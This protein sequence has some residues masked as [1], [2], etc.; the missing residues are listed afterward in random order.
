MNTD[1]ARRE[2]RPV[3]LERL[4]EVVRPEFRGDVFHPPAD[5]P[6][7]FYGICRVPACPIA[8]SAGA[9]MLCSSHYQA[10]G[11]SPD[12]EGGIDGWIASV[13]VKERTGLTACAVEGCNRSRK[14]PA[15]CSR[16]H[17]AWDAAGRPDIDGWLEGHSY[18]PP[19]GNDRPETTCEGP[20]CDRWTEGPSRRLC[21]GHD[22]KWRRAGRGD[23][24]TWLAELVHGENPRLRLD[25]LPRQLRLELQFGLQCRHDEAVKLAPIRALT[26]AVRLAAESG[27]ESLLDL[28]TAEWNIRL[29]GDRLRSFN[30][31]ARCF[32]I[33]TR[34]RL[35]ALLIE[36]DPWADQYP[37]DRWDLRL[38]GLR[39][40]Q[41][42]HL[43]FGPIPQLWLRD[44]AR[45]WCRWQLSRGL[46]PST[47]TGQLAACRKLAGYLESACPDAAPEDLTRMRVEAWL[48]VVSAALPAPTR[49]A[50][51]C[52]V[53]CFLNDV[54]RHGWEP[55]LPAG[56]LVFG[57]DLPTV[58]HGK[59][60]WIEEQ[61]MRQLEAPVALARFPTV[62][63]GVLVRILIECGL[64]LKDARTLPFDCVTRDDADAPYLAWLN[65]K[66]ADRPAF[67]PISEDLA[68]TITGQQTRVSERFPAGCRWL[69]PARSANLDGSKHLGDAGFRGQ[70]DVW[71]ERIELR[72]ARG[73]PV[74]VTAHQ[75]RHTLG[76]RL[77]NRDVPQHVVQ[78]LLDHMSPEM[79]AVYARLHDKTVRRHWE[80]ATRLNADGEAVAVDRDHPLAD[81]QWTKTRLGRA[82]VTLPNGYCGAPV[83][84]DCEYA[85]PCLDCGFFLTTVE[86]LPLHRRQRD[87]TEMMV[88]EAREQ[89]LV[90][91]VERNTRTLARLDHLIGRLEQ[92]DTDQIDSD[93][94][95][96]QADAA[97]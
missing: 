26:A 20:G 54:H 13:D 53:R 1:H 3:L 79:T 87:D 32:L 71:F 30:S 73:D 55:R 86:F 76:T 46:S 33:D 8:V 85:N 48:A 22:E 23:L 58:K 60:R 44:L 17:K 59:P 45:R 68:V 16:H 51:V 14:T 38:L 31:M 95:C 10:W 67:F 96:G 2:G 5:S 39:N 66:M 64:R 89:G 7:F 83:Q 43:D 18:R 84:T 29:G 11:R 6:V 57:D 93:D 62:D 42:R 72:D 74:R 40:G 78:Q 27:V 82:K 35:E 41:V 63:G 70:L 92:V 4:M 81:A 28:T 75:F 12:R 25:N 24:D 50:A 69:F 65:R 9:L 34:F 49:A 61:V 90:R 91:I 77:I 19:R 94:V 97:G 47:V 36:H 80:Q 37:R 15:G 88:V 21:R 52:G 56:A